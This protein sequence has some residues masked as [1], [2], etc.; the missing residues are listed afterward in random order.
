M[1]RSNCL[2]ILIGVLDAH[3]YRGGEGNRGHSM[4]VLWCTSLSRSICNSSRRSYSRRLVSRKCRQILAMAKH[5]LAEYRFLR[6]R[7]AKSAVRKYVKRTVT[8]RE[9]F[10]VKRTTT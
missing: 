1:I 10:L 8:Y 4:S 9:R 6:H 2:H 3:L 7:I 5:S